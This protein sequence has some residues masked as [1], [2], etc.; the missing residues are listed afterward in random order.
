MNVT[1][2]VKKMVEDRIAVVHE[3]VKE[4]YGREFAPVNVTYDL[5]GRTAGTAQSNTRHVR[6]NAVLLME[7]QTEFV[8][9]TVGHE[10]AHIFDKDL[11]GYRTKSN[12]KRDIHGYGWKNVMRAIGQDPAR[13]HSFDTSTSTVS[14]RTKHVWTCGCGDVT[15]SLGDKRHRRQLATGTFYMRN[16]TPDRCGAYAYTHTITGG[17]TIPVVSGPAPRPVPAPVQR[18]VPRSPRFPELT[19]STFVPE[20]A[21][22]SRNASKLEQCRA[23]WVSNSNAARQ[24]VIALFVNEVGCTPAG[25]ATYYAKIKKENS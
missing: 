3:T 11:N 24:G 12:G 1:A 23:L 17:V 14:N 25:A 7:N 20:R 22:V 5:R 4:F 2:S 6:L 21:R 15:M 18:N 19:T 10:L 8:A 13:C 16:H 9:D